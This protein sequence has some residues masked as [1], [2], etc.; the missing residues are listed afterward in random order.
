MILLFKY[1]KSAFPVFFLS[2]LLHV[3]L[4]GAPSCL[5][6]AL[7]K[8]C[9]SGRSHSWMDWSQRV[10]DVDVCLANVF[11]V[12]IFHI[13]LWTHASECEVHFIPSWP[14][15]CM[16]QCV[17][18]WSNS[19]TDVSILRTLLGHDSLLFRQRLSVTTCVS[20]F[21]F[22]SY[23]SLLPFLFIHLSL[24]PQLTHTQTCRVLPKSLFD[25]KRERMGRWRERER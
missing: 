9:H 23:L 13:C 7:F 4:F 14:L 17:C 11:Y 2:L 18:F 24:L 21:L 22:T 1:L 3:W 10:T 25:R 6:F 15:R 5:C 20:I 16:S 8:W 19:E 12:Y